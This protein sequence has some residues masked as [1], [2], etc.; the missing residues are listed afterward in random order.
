M[1]Q[2]RGAKRRRMKDPT[3]TDD[4]RIAA[5]MIARGDEPE[6]P[7]EVWERFREAEQEK[8]LPAASPRQQA[9]PLKSHP[10]LAGSATFC[11]WGNRNP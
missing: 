7:E 6:L 2:K 5:Q 9:L 11:E 3:L 10:V 1:E 8:P 4:S